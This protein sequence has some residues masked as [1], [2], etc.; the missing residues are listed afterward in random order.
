MGL[1]WSRLHCSIVLPAGAWSMLGDTP[2]PPS[3]V[4]QMTLYQDMYVRV[5]VPSCS[6]F[7][8]RQEQP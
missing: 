5:T 3:A 6:G 1:L 8:A 4:G 2:T 7:A